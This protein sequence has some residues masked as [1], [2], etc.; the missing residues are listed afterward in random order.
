M[1]ILRSCVYSHTLFLVPS[2]TLTFTLTSTFSLTSPARL[3]MIPQ[4]IYNVTSIVMFNRGP[5]N[6]AYLSRLAGAVVTF[7]NVYGQE[8]GKITLTGDYIKRYRVTLYPPTP[9][10]SGTASSS[11]TP[12]PSGTASSS[13]TS[14]GTP[15]S[16][17]TGTGTATAT[18]SAGITAS[19]TNT[20]TVTPPN[21][22][23]SSN[24]ASLTASNTP[25]ASVTPSITQ[26]PF[27]ALPGRVQ[28]DIRNTRTLNCECT[29]QGLTRAACYVLFPSGDCALKPNCNQVTALFVSSPLMQSRRS[30]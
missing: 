5:I 15:S 4:G 3:L 24:T 17:V 9:T 29:A 6:N 11:G 14:T 7:R 1:L 28:V 10:P 18:L 8:I 21:T 20:G 26:S 22:P 27:S 16:S 19:Q 25:S 13:G 2:E 12:S 30:W 23:S